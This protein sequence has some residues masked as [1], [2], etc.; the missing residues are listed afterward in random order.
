MRSYSALASA[1]LLASLA[2]SA[3][4]SPTTIGVFF[5]VGATDCDITVAPFSTFNL[6]VIAVLGTGLT[7]L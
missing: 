6:Y 3:L 1:V 7:Y 4:A 5:D 2:M